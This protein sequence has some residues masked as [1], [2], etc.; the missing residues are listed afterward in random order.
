MK[1]ELFT[2]YITERHGYK[3]LIPTGMGIVELNFLMHWSGKPRILGE[4][5][6]SP[7]KLEQVELG[8]ARK[9]NLK[10]LM[11]WAEVYNNGSL[12]F[13]YSELLSK[14][15]KAVAVV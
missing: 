12:E 5:L 13:N 14:A 2:L 15:E 7:T 9:A 4:R 11:D 3:I 6:G 8:E 10:E 1:P